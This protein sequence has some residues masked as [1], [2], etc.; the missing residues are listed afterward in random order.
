MRKPA[1]DERLS[2]S[3]SSCSETLAGVVEGELVLH[4]LEGVEDVLFEVPV[5]LGDVRCG[6]WRVGAKLDQ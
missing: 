2:V 6:Y 5:P 4:F 1:R 3:S